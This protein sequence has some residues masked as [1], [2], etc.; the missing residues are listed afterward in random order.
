M[1]IRLLTV[2]ALITLLLGCGGG[3]GSGGGGDASGANPPPPTSSKTFSA[4]LTK[5]TI[6]DTA[7][8]E[9]LSLTGLSNQGAI[10][11]LE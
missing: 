4:E 11:T 9:D 1:N 5:V 8:G 10:I 2:L 7:T 3:G 6:L